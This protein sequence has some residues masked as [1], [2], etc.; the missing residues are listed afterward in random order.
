MSIRR[1]FS[2]ESNLQEKKR[3]KTVFKAHF[4][5]KNMTEQKVINDFMGE[6]SSGV[7]AGKCYIFF[8]TLNR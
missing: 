8:D 6:I 7:L 3:S 2:E 1:L 5:K 4:H